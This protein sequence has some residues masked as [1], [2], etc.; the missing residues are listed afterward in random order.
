MLFRERTNNHKRGLQNCN[1]LFFEHLRTMFKN[2]RVSS[3]ASGKRK[4]AILCL[5]SMIFS[6]PGF[7]QSVIQGTIKSWGDQQVLP[8]ASI[9]CKELNVGT[10][11]NEKGFYSLSIPQGTYILQCSFLGYDTVEKKVTLTSKSTREDIILKE[12]TISLDDVVVTGKTQA[13]VIREQAMPVSVLQI[14]KIGGAVSNMSDVLSKTSGVTMRNSG[15]VGSSSRLSVRGLEGKRIG[16]FID[17]LP[18]SDNSDYNGLNSVPV[19]VIERIEVYKGIVPA[20][21]GGTAIGGAVNVVLKEYPPYYCEAKYTNASYNSHNASIGLK[22][23]FPDKGYL[24][25]LAGGYTYSDNDYT[26]EL[27]LQEGVFVKRDH[28][29]YEK[30]FIG[31]SFSTKKWWFDEVEFEPAF[32]STRKQI[33]GIEYNIQHAEQNVDVFSVSNKIEKENFLVEGLDLEISN[34]YSYSIF[35]FTDTA[36]FRYNWDM[37]TYIPASKYGGEIGNDANSTHNKSH[38]FIQRT[39]LNYIINQSNAIN[40]NSQYN[41]IKGLPS[42]TLRDAVFGYKTNFNSEMHSWVAGLSHEYNSGNQKLANM[43]AAKFYYYT[44][45]TSKL[46]RISSGDTEKINASKYDF[47][48]SNAIRYRFTP[49]FL[50]KASVAYDV[51]LPNELEL[52]GDGFLTAPATD[53][54]PEQ[55]RSVNLSFLYDKFGKHTHIQ[56]EMNLFYMKLANMIRFTGGMLQYQYQNFGEMRSMGVE[57]DVKWDPTPWLYLFING[58]YQDLRDTRKYEHGTTPNFTKGDRMPNIPYLMANAGFEL[59]KSN[60]LG[61]NTASR[62][63]VDGS[64]V[65]EYYYNFKKSNYSEPK[66]PRQL[67][68]NLGVEHSILKG[69]VVLGFQLNNLTNAKMISEF[70][71]P[72][73]GRNYALKIRYIWKKM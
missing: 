2:N 8:G 7:S 49:S 52:L 57:V 55:N 68:V 43:F 28:D 59:H 33:Q 24:L 45:K 31:G 10:V 34:I 48:V 27:P 50:V 30:K 13:R 66:I 16:I 9:Y 62:L 37:T 63:F 53:L 12:L 65:E 35:Q 22:R 40:L 70:N 18:L 73:P 20:R 64:F 25:G 11:A 47:G 42:D 51:R 46:K 71:R 41:Y 23:N 17:G 54:S 1:P 14:D 3:H 36:S 4:Y 39:N 44:M 60:L 38:N 15:G 58:T 67:G 19:D 5:L 29:Q 32:M 61:R 21:F 69:G 72:L 56:V 6:L 26:M